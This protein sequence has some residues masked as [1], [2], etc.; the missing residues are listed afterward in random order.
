[1]AGREHFAL[2]ARTRADGGAL[3]DA[4]E[5]TPGRGWSPFPIFARRE[6]STGR[7]LDSLDQRSTVSL[8]GP[9]P[10]V[11]ESPRNQSWSLGRQT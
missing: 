6:L 4:I 7:G 5:L 1:M 10:H 2:P 8:T 9:Y 3:F 11:R